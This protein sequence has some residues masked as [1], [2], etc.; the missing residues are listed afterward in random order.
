M[1]IACFYLN[2]KKD[3][4]SRFEIRFNGNFAK[5]DE[6][7]SFI[8]PADTVLFMSLTKKNH[9]QLQLPDV[10]NEIVTLQMINNF[11]VKIFK[12]YSKDINEEGEASLNF[13]GLPESGQ[14]QE[15]LEGD[16]KYMTRFIRQRFV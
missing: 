2:P 13:M 5:Q 15:S 11:Y 4:M 1:E 7:N 6:K 9:E 16:M 12:I 3:K 10:P 14:P 8:N